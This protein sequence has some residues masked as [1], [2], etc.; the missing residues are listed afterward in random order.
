MS[1]T[2]QSR[3]GCLAAGVALLAS[4]SLLGGC[5]TASQY[6]LN[7]TPGI[8]GAAYTQDQ[9][10]NMLTVTFDTNLRQ[11]NEDVGRLFLLDRPMRTRRHTL[12]Y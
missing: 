6:R 11:F 2:I 8:R 4:A 1:T 12:P 7:P 10:D 3:S 5:D 9:V